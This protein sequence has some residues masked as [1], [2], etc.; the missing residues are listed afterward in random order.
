MEEFVPYLLIIIGWHPDHPGEF[1]FH[2][3]PIAYADTDACEA[4]G[5]EYV[6]Q[7]DIYRTEFGGMQ[8]AYKCIRSASGDEYQ[9]ALR[10]LDKSKADPK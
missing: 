9:Q 5:R 10:D 8:F 6:A 7:R 1:S 4:D 2:R 3:A